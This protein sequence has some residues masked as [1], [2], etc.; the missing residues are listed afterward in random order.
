MLSA[1]PLPGV[2]DATTALAVRPL[3]QTEAE[4]LG[5]APE[6]LLTDGVPAHFTHPQRRRE[7]LAGRVLAAELLRGLLPP[8]LADTHRIAAD[9]FGRPR[10]L[11]AAG[12]VVGALSLSHSGDAV[13]AIVALGP[14]RR[15][16]LDL[17]PIRVKTLTLAPRFL[18]PDE[19]AALGDST[20]RASLLWS[21][22]ETLYKAYG[23][24]QL[25]FRQHLHL[26]TSEWPAL[27]AP[28]PATGIVR[29]RITHPTTGHVW[30]HTLHYRTVA[31]GSDAGS[32]AGSGAGSFSGWLTYCVS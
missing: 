13:A 30:Q 9:A 5:A 6:W 3:T 28:L 21:L 8:A 32:L 1:S 26:D 10:L 20:A 4:L 24:R 7:W 23:R 12:D 27:P 22:K 14:G 31:P 25:D 19:C 18:S 11:D 17:E 2:L 15:V 16:G 29:G